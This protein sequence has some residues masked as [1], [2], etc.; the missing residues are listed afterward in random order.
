MLAVANLLFA[1]GINLLRAESSSQV[2]QGRQ[3]K[4]RISCVRFL[5]SEP[6]LSSSSSGPLAPM[7]G[8]RRGPSIGR[9]WPRSCK[10][11]APPPSGSPF[12]PAILTMAITI[13]RSLGSRTKYTRD[14]SEA[15]VREVR[16]WPIPDWWSQD[17]RQRGR[18]NSS[19]PGPALTRLTKFVVRRHEAFGARLGSGSLYRPEAASEI[20]LADIALRSHDQ[21][22]T[23]WRRFWCSSFRAKFW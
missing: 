9:L 20:Q 1:P 18:V 5:C 6:R 12:R 21:K 23:V 17:R 16:K 14:D 19:S 8:N 10:K 15:P 4:W 13:R 22:P 11:G 7:L 3:S 2:A